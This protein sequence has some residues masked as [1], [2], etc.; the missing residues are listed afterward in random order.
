MS[1][2]SGSAILDVTAIGCVRGGGVAADAALA[3]ARA[4]GRAAF[5]AA[6]GGDGS[7]RAL[8]LAGVV[9]DDAANLLLVRA[10][11]TLLLDSSLWRTEDGQTAALRAGTVA[12]AAGRG[13]VLALCGAAVVHRCRPALLAYLRSH[14]DLLLCGALEACALY[15][16]HRID[17]VVPLLRRDGRATVLDRGARGTIVI[18]ADGA[19]VL[20]ASWSA[21]AVL[22]ARQAV[23][24]LD[25]GHAFGPV[26]MELRRE[27]R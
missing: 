7:F 4:G 27:A 3:A 23:A 17:T 22:V 1:A 16:T 9:V 25:P 24:E 2:R 8:R 14:V 10:A 5:L 26:N 15:D 13:T 21:A 20:D 6:G 19:R 18:D 11:R 12:R